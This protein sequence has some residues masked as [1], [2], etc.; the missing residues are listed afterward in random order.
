MRVS[1]FFMVATETGDEHDV[2]PDHE[3]TQ[4]GCPLRPGHEMLDLDDRPD[5]R[6]QTARGDGP[7]I[8]LGL[9]RRGHERRGFDHGHAS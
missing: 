3:L 4:A 8:S 6:P 9:P 2:M 1:W 7:V 5:R